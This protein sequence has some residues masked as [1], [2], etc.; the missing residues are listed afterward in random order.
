MATYLAS[1]LSLL[2]NWYSS[3]ADEEVPP[4]YDTIGGVDNLPVGYIGSIASA[5][6]HDPAQVDSFTGEPSATRLVKFFFLILSRDGWSLCCRRPP[7]LKREH[8]S[9][10]LH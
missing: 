7:V 5:D 6:V 2:L 3:L 4:S 10:Y 9:V 8:L 1:V